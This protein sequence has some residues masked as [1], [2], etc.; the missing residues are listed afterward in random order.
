MVVA[1]VGPQLMS[2]GLGSSPSTFAIVSVCRLV[3]TVKTEKRKVGSREMP[4]MMLMQGI[5][6]CTVLVVVPSDVYFL[7]CQEFSTQRAS[8]GSS[9]E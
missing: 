3:G 5:G 1:V 7:R 6:V 4:T 8:S 9:G 2:A